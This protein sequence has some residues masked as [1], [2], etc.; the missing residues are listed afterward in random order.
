M[1]SRGKRRGRGDGKEMRYGWTEEDSKKV[2]RLAVL[3]LSLRVMDA[4]RPAA[5]ML[6][7]LRLADMRARKAMAV[8]R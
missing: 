3:L 8:L 6:M 1:R 5:E 2:R 7:I 4:R